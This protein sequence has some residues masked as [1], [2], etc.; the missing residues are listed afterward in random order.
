[1]PQPTRKPLPIRAAAEPGLEEEP[2]GKATTADAQLSATTMVEVATSNRV[3]HNRCI[4]GSNSSHNIINDSRSNGSTSS[5]DIRSHS[6]GDIRSIT[7]TIAGPA[8]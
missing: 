1:M 5:G 7:S 4:L 3:I 8:G 6:S 2:I